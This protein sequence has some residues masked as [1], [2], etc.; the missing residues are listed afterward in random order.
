[1]IGGAGLIARFREGTAKAGLDE[2][3]LLSKMQMS[4][5]R[6]W[7]RPYDMTQTDVDA[8]AL[9][10]AAMTKHLPKV[11]LSRAELAGS[12][13]EAAKE[14]YPKYAARLVVDRLAECDAMFAAPEDPAAEPS[15]ARL[16][17]LHVIEAG[18]NLAREDKDYATLLTLDLVIAGNAAHATTHEKLDQLDARVA[19]R[20]EEDRQIG[21]EHSALLKQILAAVGGDAEERGVTEKALIELAR[22]VADNIPDAAQAIAQLQRAIDEYIGLRDQAARGS[23]LGDLVDEALRRIAAQNEQGKFD[24]GADEGARAYAELIEQGQTLRAA[25]L[26]IIAANIDQHRMRVD[27]EAIALWICEGLE[28]EH[29]RLTATALFPEIERY[30]DKGLIFGLRLEL[31]VA[32]KL[33]ARAAANAEGDGELAAAL[34][35]QGIVSSDQGERTGGEAGLVLLDD[36]VSAYRAALA[37]YTETTMPAKWAMAQNNLAIALQTQGERTGGEA[38]LALLQAAVSAYRTVLTVYTETAVPTYWATTQNNL[39]IALQTQGGRTGGEAGLA[40]LDEAVLAYRA[41]LTVY[42]ETTTPVD[43]AMTQNNL[44]TVLKTQGELVGGAAGLELLADATSACRAALTVRTETTMPA[45]WAT[46]QNNLGNT[47]G[48]RGGWTGGEAGLALLDEAVSA[49]RRALTVNTETAMS[50]DWAMTQNNLA[51]A[52]RTKGERTKGEAGLALLDDAAS[53]YRAALTVNTETAMPANWAMTTE[54]LA[55]CFETMADNHERSE[56]LDDL[57]RAEAALLD[58]LRVYSA[59]HMPYYHEKA[60][61]GLA[62]IHRKIEDLAAD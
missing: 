56:A 57:R 20:A 17:A 47:L 35:L 55:L 23:N 50:A 45:D 10:D 6:D 8:L 12:S 3:A 15:L 46:T 59:E 30:R 38:G 11:M 39:A 62:R 52:L 42:N 29:G 18:L 28:V 9:A 4:V 2:P 43:W 32:I 34:N 58:T 61:G 51:N 37:I 16:F 26:N 21:G 49:Y 7:T 53:A 14:P 48:I 25:K 41:A 13:T 5:L 44:A 54:N 40:L 24:A 22:R 31:D 36:A 33:A 19:A 1:M 60:T 27:A